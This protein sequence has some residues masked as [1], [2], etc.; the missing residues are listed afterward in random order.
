MNTKLNKTAQDANADELFQTNLE[1]ETDDPNMA[2]KPGRSIWVWM[3]AIII[4]T[5][6]TIFFIIWFMSLPPTSFKENTQFT[7]TKGESLQTITIN[8]Q[9][10]NLTRSAFLLQLAIA[11]QYDP[12]GIKAGVY[13]FNEPMN[14]FEVAQVLSMTIPESEL[15]RIT[16]PEGVTVR[17]IADIAHRSLPDF[18]Y[19]EF[20]TLATPLEGRLFP[21]TYHIPPEFSAKELVDLLNQKSTEKLKP[22]QSQIKEHK[23]NEE[24]VLILA[25]LIEREANDETSMRMVSGILQ[26]RLEISMPLQ[27]DASIEYVLDKPLSE[28]TPE[29]LRMESP[30]NTYLN[31]GL[32]PTPIGNP[33]MT[34]IKAVLDPIETDYLFYITARDGQFYYARDFDQHRN[35]IARYLR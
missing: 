35:N 1:I 26:N 9:Q 6:A 14:V 20:L 11:S 25:S 3:V 22:L 29:D 24:E 13:T 21:D 27:A 34:S 17:A 7:V 31:T 18:E 32:M 8:A 2:T 4:L 23:L 16:I 12:R 28:L 33:G 10:Q 30:Y 15:I 19:E 5:P